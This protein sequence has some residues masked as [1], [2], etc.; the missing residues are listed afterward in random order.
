MKKILLG[1]DYFGE[2]FT[3]NESAR[4]FKALAG[5]AISV[6]VAMFIIAI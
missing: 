2:S 1:N 5:L 6:S 4:I 3:M